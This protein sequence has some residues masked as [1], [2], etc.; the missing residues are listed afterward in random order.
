MHR[1]CVI[2]KFFCWYS[3]HFPTFLVEYCCADRPHLMW[4]FELV[5]D[6][7]RVVPGEDARIRDGGEF[8]T[9]LHPTFG[10]VF[11]YLLFSFMKFHLWDSLLVSRS[12]IN[13]LK[14]NK[15]KGFR[16][17]KKRDFFHFFIFFATK[18]A[19]GSPTEKIE[20]KFDFS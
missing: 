6:S 16:K 2:G 20:E 12:E 10:D 17:S 5:E 15:H 3:E 4:D 11:E 1:P 13:L 18:P 7:M 8:G 14:A 19:K 9:G